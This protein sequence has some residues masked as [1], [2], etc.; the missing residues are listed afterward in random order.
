MRWTLTIETQLLSNEKF[1]NRSSENVPLNLKLLVS[2]F[3]SLSV[4]FFFSVSWVW[5]L[6]LFNNGN[7]WKKFSLLHTVAHTGHQQFFFSDWNF[8]LICLLRNWYFV[9]IF[10]ILQL[11]FLRKKSELPNFKVHKSD[12]YRVV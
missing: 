8:Y 9:I 6:F 11:R 2:I 7:L 12:F 5:I 4:P 10:K 1:G 3:F